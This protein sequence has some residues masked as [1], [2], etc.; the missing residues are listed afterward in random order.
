MK[1]VRSIEAS[2]AGRPAGTVF[3]I[4]NDADADAMIHAGWVMETEDDLT[5]ESPG[6]SEEVDLESMKADDLRDMARDR[7]LPTSGTKSELIE[8]LEG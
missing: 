2:Y 1:R 5:E 3:E 6:E 8:R 7:G 4:E